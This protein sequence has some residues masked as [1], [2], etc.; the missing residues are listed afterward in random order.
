MRT[1]TIVGFGTM[2]SAVAQL[3]AQ[4]GFFVRGY[5]VSEDALRKGLDGIKTG[6][7]GLD[8]MVKGNKMSQEESNTVLSRISVTTSLEESLRGT[9]IVVENVNED[10]ALKKKVFNKLDELCEEG[11]ILASDTSSLSITSIAAETKHGERVVGMHLFIPPQVMPLVEIINGLATSKD[12]VDK[13]AEVA[14]ELGKVV[15]VSKD[16][17]GFV[18]ARLGLRQFVEACA[19][20]EQGIASI[21]DVDVGAKKGLGHPMGPFELTDLIGLDTRMDI[22]DSMFSETGDPSWKAPALLRQLVQSGYRGN[23]ALKKGSKGGFYEFFGLT[24]E[25]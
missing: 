5:D 20:V 19:I 3:F 15:I 6:R 14:R 11:V 18:V 13:L 4:K 22:L 7:F 25:K 8:A 17:P 2:G 23:P 24:R 10:L 1:A 21:R 16:R 12:T 9:T